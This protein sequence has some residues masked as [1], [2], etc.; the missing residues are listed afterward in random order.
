MKIGDKVR[1]L[2]EVGGGVVVSF[3]GSGTVNVRD[4]DGFEIPM[5]MRECVV[6]ETDSYNR[7]L[8]Q[9]PTAKSEA[10]NR[11]RSKQADTV[12]HSFDDD[13][14]WKPVTFRPRPVERRGAD[15]LSLLLAFVPQSAEEETVG[16]YA[17]YIIND[18]NYF[19][20]FA[21]LHA[22][23]KGYKVMQEDLLEPNTKIFLE[24]FPHTEINNWERLT[25][26]GFA[27]KE[28]REFERKA[29]F[30]IDLKNDCTKFY[31][32]HSFVKNEFFP[33]PALLFRI[34]DEKG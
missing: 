20:R 12:T 30:D 5:L 9:E 27:Y 2:N 18:S 22:G 24:E 23:E 6:V 11:F 8:P 14:D 25:I 17:A 15:S 3:T 31:K 26:Q 28:E 13:E 29:V 34:L 10:D 1:F 32:F 4:E 19:V 21:M 33:K 16:T 7:A